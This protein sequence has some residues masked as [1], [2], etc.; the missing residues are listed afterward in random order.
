MPLQ[1]KHTLGAN[2]RLKSR[3]DI[4]QLFA[5]G[6]SLNHFPLKLYWQKNAT[7]K[8]P[9]VGFAVSAR[10]FKKATDRNRIKR[11]LR[12]AY[13]LQKNVI[14]ENAQQ[15]LQLF[16]VYVDKTLPNFADLFAKTTAALKKLNKLL[17]AETKLSSS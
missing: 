10:F 2:E 12:E 1:R 17:L 8:A 14:E 11:L 5:T 16:I 4:Q 9:Q 3:K 6:K 13:R 7:T 15:S